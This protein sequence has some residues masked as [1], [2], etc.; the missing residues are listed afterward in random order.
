MAGRVTIV[1]AEKIVPAGEID[2]DCI[3][4]PGI[5]VKKVLQ[6]SEAESSNKGIEQYTVR[7]RA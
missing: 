7:E 4:L 1:E 3:H 5:Y 6:L 2:P